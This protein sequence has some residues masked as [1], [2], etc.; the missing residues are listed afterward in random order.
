MPVSFLKDAVMEITFGAVQVEE[1]NEE[2]S[3][4]ILPQETEN[5]QSIE[6]RKQL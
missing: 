1:D 3:I 4:K 5:E 2:N 6:Q